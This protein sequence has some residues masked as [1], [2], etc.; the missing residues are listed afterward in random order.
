MTP[1]E[2]EQEARFAMAAGLF[3]TQQLSLEQAAT[4]AAINQSAFLMRLAGLRSAKINETR[5]AVING[6][7]EPAKT[8][9]TKSTT[10]CLPGS[11]ALSIPKDSTSTC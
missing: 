7:D 8:R 1:A 5:D 3:E 6:L 9:G 11:A 2:F 4:L 10:A